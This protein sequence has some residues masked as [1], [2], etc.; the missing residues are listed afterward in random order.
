M[1]QIRSTLQ[2][3][4]FNLTKTVEA[5]ETDQ[6]L[7]KLKKKRNVIVINESENNFKCTENLEFLKEVSIAHDLNVF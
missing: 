1:V 5:L 6:N 7:R 3:N 4:N 2:A